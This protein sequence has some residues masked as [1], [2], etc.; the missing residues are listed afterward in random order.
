[1][2]VTCVQLNERIIMDI[3]KL[4]LCTEVKVSHMMQ[5]VTINPVK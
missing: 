3:K 5:F 4:G 1:M 2:H